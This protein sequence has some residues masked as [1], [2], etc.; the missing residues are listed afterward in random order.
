MFN[1]L[2]NARASGIAITIKN[3]KMKTITFVL[4]AFSM[5]SCDFKTE[6]PDKTKPMTAEEHK[7]KLEALHLD[8]SLPVEIDSSEYVMYPLILE[9]NTEKEYGSFGKGSRVT[10]WNIVFYNTGNG[11]YHLLDDKRKMIIYAYGPYNSDDIDSPSSPNVKGNMDIGQNHVDKLL[12]Y[13]IITTDF[14]QDGILNSK[15]PG[16]LFIS[17]KAGKHFKQISP[18]KMSVD[19]WQPIRNTNK[20]LIHVIADSNKDKKFSAEDKKIP[21]VYDLNKNGT[22][23]AVFNEAFQLQLKT[24]LDNQ[25]AKE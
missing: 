20:I 3:I 25:W 21:M 4:L 18:D 7:I 2:Y 19:S 23:K 10:Y 17:D 5:F 8:F 14:N 24:L 16:Y 13:S 22:S 12:Y 11:A 6:M 9:D 15:D 1:I